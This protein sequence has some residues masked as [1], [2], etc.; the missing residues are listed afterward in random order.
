MVWLY[1]LES[2]VQSLEQYIIF[3]RRQ[4]WGDDPAIGDKDHMFIGFDGL[5]E[6]WID[7]T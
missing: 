1:I 2:L 7:Q 5:Y 4:G 3:S 6:G